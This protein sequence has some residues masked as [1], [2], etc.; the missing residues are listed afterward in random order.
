MNTH[1][2]ERL[3]FSGSYNIT[4][5][6]VGLVLVCTNPNISCYIITIISIDI[7]KCSSNYAIVSPKNEIHTLILKI[8]IFI[9]SRYDY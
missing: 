1:E 2:T 9:Y 6:T 5:R 3:H 8:I 4:E 7:K